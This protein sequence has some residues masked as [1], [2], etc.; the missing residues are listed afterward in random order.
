MFTVFF[1]KSK[2]SNYDHTNSLRFQTQASNIPPE[3]PIESL[4]TGPV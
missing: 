3:P 1:I 2:L 4:E